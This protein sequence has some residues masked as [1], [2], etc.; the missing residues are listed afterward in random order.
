MSVLQ[1]TTDMLKEWQSWD[2]EMKIKKSKQ[3]IIDWYDHYKG[4]VFVSFSGGKDSTVLLHLVRQTI[5]EK[6]PDAPPVEAVFSNTGLE[7]PEIVSFV[8]KQDNVTIIRPKLTY[9]EVVKKYGYALISKEQSQYID[10]Y[11]NTKSQK[12]KDLRW[13]GREKGS[14]SMISK[15]WRFLTDAPFKISNK[16]CTKLKKDPFK[17]FAK[18]SGKKGYVG[19][20]AEESMLRIQTY[21]AHGCNAYDLKIP[22][23]RPLGHWLEQDIWDYIGA[24]GLE[25][26]EAYTKHN[27]DRTGCMWCAFGVHLEQGENK[28]QKLKKTHPKIWDYCMN[29]MGLKDVLEYIGVE[30]GENKVNFN[31]GDWEK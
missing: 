5:K 26:S 22:Q 19:I 31:F 2:L 29:K 25:I 15:K 1:I 3:T 28:F 9:L 11:R 7:Y 6:Y 30:T 12:L 23:S 20:M 4:E 16:C 13:N 24:Y 18:T 8:K 27:Y 17:Q 21:V 10:E 14:G